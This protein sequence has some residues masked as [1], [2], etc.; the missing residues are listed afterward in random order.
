YYPASASPSILKKC[1]REDAVVVIQSFSKA[2]CMTGWRLGWLVGRKDLVA[3]ATQLNEIM[4]SCAP[5]FA[6][7]AGE[8]ALVWGEE[9][10]RQMLGALRA[11]RD[12]CYAALRK[13]PGV[14][15]PSA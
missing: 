12:F 11:N 13:I 5:S 6:Q 3:R 15:A 7:K 1:T 8:T 14:R 10:L 4:V 2:Y 9:P